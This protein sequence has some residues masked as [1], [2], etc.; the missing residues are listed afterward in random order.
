MFSWLRRCWLG[1]IGVGSVG[2]GEFDSIG[3]GAV[4]VGIGVM[5]FLRL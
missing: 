3:C 4:T 2:V 5:V 1:A